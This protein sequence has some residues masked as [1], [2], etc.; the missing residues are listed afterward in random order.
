MIVETTVQR[1]HIVSIIFVAIV[2]LIFGK[3]KM[4]LDGKPQPPEVKQ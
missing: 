1:K 4:T 2:A 3:C